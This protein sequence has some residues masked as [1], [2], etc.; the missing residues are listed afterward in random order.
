MD[1][2]EFKK[3]ENSQLEF[4]WDEFLNW[5]RHLT[6]NYDSGTNKSETVNGFI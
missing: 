3:W 1:M 5:D 4:T 6:M 2:I